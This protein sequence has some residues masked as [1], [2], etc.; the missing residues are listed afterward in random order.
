MI[1]ENRI[2][3][4]LTRTLQQTV[5]KGL[6]KKETGKVRD[7]YQQADR[8]ILITTDRISAFDCVL[9]TIP[10]KGQVLNQLAA[11]WFKQTKAI[12]PNHV[13]DIPDPNVMTVAECE[14]LPL[15]F[16]VRGYI[17][18]VTKTSLWHNYQQGVREY[19]GNL[20]PDGLRK[21]QKLDC[22]ILT[23][24]TKLEHHDRPIAREQAIAEGLV[25]AETFDAAAD[26]CFRLFDFGVRHAKRQGL[27]LVDTKYELGWRNGELMVSDEIHTPDSSRYW[28]T[29][30]YEALFAEG[31]EQR[32]L[33]KEYIR[34]WYAARGF[35]GEG[36]PPVMPD[37]I[38]IEA[39]KRYIQAYEVITGR[40]FIVMDEPI[41]QRILR[42]LK[43][44]GYLDV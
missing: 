5:F 8:R 43:S 17:T 42:A 21:N 34:E 29:D 44:K 9:G 23:P 37:D 15:E 30:T 1:T 7:C 22:P 24:T 14:Q 40:E 10:F 28:L 12:A 38:R 11:F 20:L 32:K 19:C 41:D 26:I 33:D 39:A 36:T 4:E 27:I 18:G 25:D 3:E 13:I 31:S 2:R 16:V 6:G 35:R